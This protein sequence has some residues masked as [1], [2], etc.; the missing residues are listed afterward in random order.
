MVMSDMGTIAENSSAGAQRHKN[1]KPRNLYG[2]FIEQAASC[3]EHALP[4]QGR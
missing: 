3:T 2:I 4:G 1:E